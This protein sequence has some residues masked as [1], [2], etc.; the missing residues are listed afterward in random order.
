M[1]ILITG[2]SGYIGE[3]LV[4]Q[5]LTDG[6]VVF[7]ASR[8]PIAAVNAKYLPYDLGEYES[9]RLPDNIDFIFHLAANTK[10]NSVT[11]AV[12][13]AAAA[14]LV[15][16]SLRSNAKFIFIS[17]QVARPDAPTEYGQTKWEIEQ[18]V[19][20]AGGIVIRPG[21]VYGGPEN[22]LY[23]RLC[24][25]LRNLPFIPAFV[26]SPLI[27]PIH[28]QDLVKGLLN[29][30]TLENYSG[31]IFK[32]GSIDPISFTFFL[33]S[34]ARIHN[35]KSRLLLPIPT[36]AVLAIIKIIGKSFAARTGLDKLKSLMDVP[37]MDTKAD[38]SF[39]RLQLRSL[40]S[41]L[42]KSGRYNRHA[43]IIEGNSLLTYILKSTPS[44][45]LIKIYVRAIESL[46]D[47]KPLGFLPIFNRWPILLA[48]LDT[49]EGR[50]RTGHS[51]FIWRLRAAVAIAETSAEDVERFLETPIQSG[52]LYSTLG[53]ARALCMD[54]IWRLLSNVCIFI[55][56]KLFDFEKTTDAC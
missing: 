50:K 5:A 11:P 37:L 39:L 13:I 15:N 46:R 6:H 55:A 18:R 2:A 41:G 47:K 33:Q 30:L 36:F 52:V 14:N 4:L 27:Q 42:T 56:P 44:V 49:P 24:S 29:C 53:L 48:L 26:P 20:A 31:Q 8:S 23:G 3:Q 51:E 1:R 28:I 17:S 22:G 16:A 45:S 7:A 9:F 19:L 25:S 40:Q 10:S 12:E 32:L 21:Q 43:L 54:T 38:L 34:I 35:N